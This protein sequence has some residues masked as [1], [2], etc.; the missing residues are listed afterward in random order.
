MRT[1]FQLL[2]IAT[3]GLCLVASKS[4]F[5][6]A[7]P[8][9][10]F[11]LKSVDGKT[12]TEKV[13]A[14]HAATAIVFIGTGCPVAN[15]YLPELKQL[16]ASFASQGVQVLGVNSNFGDDAETIKK[17]AADFQV[18]FPVLIDAEQKLASGLS[19][20]RTPEVVVVDKKGEIRYRGRIDDRHGYTYRRDASTRADLEEAIKEVLA[21]KAVSVARTEPV[22]CLLH[23]HPDAIATGDVT[24]AQ[25]VSRIINN[26]CGY[27]H[28]AGAA[29]PFNLQTYDDVAKWADAIKEVV[30][31]NRMPPW[32][33]TASFGHFSNDRRLTDTERQLLLRWIDEGRSKGDEKDLPPATVYD[34]SGWMIGKPDLVLKMP[35]KVDVQAD[36]VVAYQYYV[37]PTNFKEDMWITAA[38]AK[39]GNRGVVHHIIIFFR[40]P[41]VKM[42]IGEPDGKKFGF[43]VGT[44]PGDMPLVLPPGVARRIPAGA[45]LVWQMH[46]TPTGKP[47]EDLSEVGLIF[48][49]GPEP[50][51]YNSITKG[52]SQ[53]WFKIPANADNHRVESNFVF[54]EDSILLSFMP[55]MHL[56]GKA[57]LYEAIYPDGK[58]E[59]L[60]DVPKYDFN[61]QSA[62]RLAQPKNMP[63]GTKIHCVA[64]FD[65]SKN[66]PANPDPT[67]SVVWGDQTWEEMMIGWID[68]MNSKPL[69]PAVADK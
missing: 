34:D 49:K 58:K 38:E 50:V 48:H 65:N 18:T 12:W 24:F 67:K 64:H 10:A 19:I 21:D 14:D 68:Y 5:A 25:Q 26:K 31:E 46:Y 45:E 57:F 63:A 60:L 59:V 29:A 16:Q 11:E 47:E 32:H 56:R 1:S 36:G 69:E 8:S 2:A 42:P 52:I 53:R 13:F 20:A 37:T 3:V 27:C 17:H 15:L 54:K 44:A 30:N 23:R 35:H 33:A 22:G 39:A 41:K 28:R 9:I 66:N 62:Y 40:D 55:H 6:S 4:G 61:W 7:A 51:K 43:L